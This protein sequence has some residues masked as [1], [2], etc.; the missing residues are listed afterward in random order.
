MDPEAKEVG[1]CDDGEEDDC[2]ANV[3]FDAAVGWR[4][5]AAE[6]DGGSD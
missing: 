5:E 4:V 3:E 1:Q 6:C 2:C